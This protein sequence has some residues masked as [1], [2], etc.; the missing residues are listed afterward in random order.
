[1]EDEAGKVLAIF[2]YQDVSL[3]EETRQTLTEGQ[4]E[5]NYKQV[6]MKYFAL[7]TRHSIILSERDITNFDELMDILWERCPEDTRGPRTYDR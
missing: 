1:M 4:Y 6:R 7:E 3:L 2:L 5:A